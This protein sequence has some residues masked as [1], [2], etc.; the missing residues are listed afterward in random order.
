MSD[1][2]PIVVWRESKSKSVGA[3]VVTNKG[4]C[5]YATIWGAHDMNKILGYNKM[6]F[7]GDQEP[8]L[9]VLMN[10]IKAL[11]G[12]QCTL[13]ESP[14]GDSQ[15]NGDVESAVKQIQ[16][17]FRTMRSDLEACYKRVIEANHNVM[18]HLVRHCAGTMNRESIGT[19]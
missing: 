10:R 1:E 15:S 11:S 7:K 12:D 2:Y 9:R 4:E 17:Q 3:Y 16:G 5:E 18:P 19:D 6:N 14:V 13:D 8:A